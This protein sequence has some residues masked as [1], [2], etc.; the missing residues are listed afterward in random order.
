MNLTY[1]DA[2]IECTNLEVN[3]NDG[4]PQRLCSDCAAKLT[5][6]YQFRK[7]A[8]DSDKILRSYS[9]MEKNENEM[10]ENAKFHDEDMFE[11]ETLEELDEEC[12]QEE[13]MKKEIFSDVSANE[14]I[15]NDA[16]SFLTGILKKPQGSAN[17]VVEVKK[18]KA[19]NNIDSGGEDPQR[20][21]A[22]NVC[23]KK[24]QK[25]SNLIDH[26]RLHANVKVFSCEFCEK[27]FVQA[28]NFK[29]HLRTHTK[30]KPYQCHYCSKSYSQSSSLKIH[31]RLVY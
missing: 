12:S 18:V 20:K 17:R 4:F 25:R 14:T 9:D 28:G 7:E 13:G 21:H 23:N 3:Q 26:L 10:Y 31:I 6:A 8:V 24:F 30:E 16:V 22:C 11:Y 27:S 15:G 5:I 2:F 1:S 29:A 19:K